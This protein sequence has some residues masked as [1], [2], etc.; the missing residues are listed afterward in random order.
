MREA[1]V[2]QDDIPVTIIKCCYAKLVHTHTVCILNSR[3]TVLETYTWGTCNKHLYI[4]LD[5]YMQQT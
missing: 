1:Q 5:T 2:N 3:H 4:T